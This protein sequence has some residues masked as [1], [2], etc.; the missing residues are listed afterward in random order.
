MVTA[1][2]FDEKQKKFCAFVKYYDL[3]NQLR[4]MTMDVTDDWVIDSTYG[5][6][7]TKKL[8]DHAE[9]DRFLLPPTDAQGAL[10]TIKV[11]DD[12]VLRVKYIPETFQHETDQEGKL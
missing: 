5:A 8:M 6:V 2:W 3:S 9:N 1:L 10:A 12:K 4:E 7:L 11:N